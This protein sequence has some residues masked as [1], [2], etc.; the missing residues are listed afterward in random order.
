M[1]RTDITFPSGDGECAGWFF[2]A[3]GADAPAPCVVMAHGLAAIKEMRLDAY[4]ERFA[5]AGFHVVVFDYRHFGASPGEPRQLL[6]IGRQHDDYRAA[7][8]WA[9]ARPEVDATRIALWGSSFSGGHVMALAGELGATAAVAQVPHA[10]GI[11][12]TRAMPLTAVLPLAGAG[13]VDAVGALLGRPPKYLAAVGAPGQSG[14]VLTAPEALEYLDLVPVGQ[15]FDN[16]LAARFMLKVGL[17][18]PGR[19]LTSL[20]APILVQVGRHDETTPPGAA[21]KAGERA[22]NGT[23]S[24]YDVGHFGAY[25]GEGFET[26]VSEQVKFLRQHLGT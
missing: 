3:E 1:A 24:V 23:V 14:A 16:R 11:A 20:D 6:D 22:K 4:A 17:Y 25:T 15:P 8:A 18:S 19:K 7:V 10:D 13:I 21:I 9:R 26:F 5:A 12:S 2:D